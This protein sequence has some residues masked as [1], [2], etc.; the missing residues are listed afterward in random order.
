MGPVEL[1]FLLRGLAIDIL[2]EKDDDVIFPKINA[3]FT[4]IELRDRGLN[5]LNKHQLSDNLM[6]L[7]N[8]VLNID[9]IDTSY[10][11]DNMVNLFHDTFSSILFLY[12]IL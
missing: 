12:S 7:S 4:I 11:A 8:Y 10:W 1:S 9:N 2:E 3:I 5:S 6:I